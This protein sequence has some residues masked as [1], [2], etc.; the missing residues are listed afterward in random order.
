MGKT[1]SFSTVYE[2]NSKDRKVAI[3]VRTTDGTFYPGVKHPLDAKKKIK[4]KI[5][6]TEPYKPKKFN[7]RKSRRK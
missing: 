4:Q 5:V 1:L 6:I 2:K 7:I 3:G